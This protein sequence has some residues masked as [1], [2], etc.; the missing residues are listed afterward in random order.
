MGAT[1]SQRAYA[2]LV[3]PAKLFYFIPDSFVAKHYFPEKR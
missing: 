3:V 1:E 2:S